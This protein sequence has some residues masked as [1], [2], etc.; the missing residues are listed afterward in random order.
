M[1]MVVSSPPN[2][3]SAPH[4]AWQRKQIQII[5]NCNIDKRLI[6]LSIPAL[7]SQLRILLIDGDVP[8][9]SN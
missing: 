7:N 5:H 4:S 2:G 6:A 1:D 8:L 9:S 3:I